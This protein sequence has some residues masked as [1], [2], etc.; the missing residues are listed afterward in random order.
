MAE[1]T[2]DGD[3]AA[4]RAAV[5][6]TDWPEWATAA[7]ETGS[8]PAVREPDDLTLIVAGADLPIPARLLPVVGLPA[9]PRHARD[10]GA[11]GGR[12]AVP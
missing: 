1:R 7:A 4:G 8:I 9:V 11:P 6:A 10:R 5:R 3:G 12:V 2:A